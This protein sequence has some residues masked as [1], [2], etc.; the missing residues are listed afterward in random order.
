MLVILA[1]NWY[2]QKGTA[3]NSKDS[4]PTLMNPLNKKDGKSEENPGNKIKP[5]VA[6]H[7]LNAELG[8]RGDE[9]RN[10]TPMTSEANGK[11]KFW[12]QKVKNWATTCAIY[13]NS[14][15]KIFGTDKCLGIRYEVL[16]SPDSFGGDSEIKE[17]NHVTSHLTISGQ[18]VY[19]DMTSPGGRELP[20]TDDMDDIR[21]YFRGDWRFDN[22]EIHNE[23]EHLRLKTSTSKKRK[24][25]RG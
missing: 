3:T 9:T 6:A 15:K 4:I 20:F 7:L 22:I 25:E 8:G 2:N 11:M 14:K 17:Y 18:V 10:L 24:R 5:W 1:P 23:D 21:T 19:M 13:M 16:V 12:E